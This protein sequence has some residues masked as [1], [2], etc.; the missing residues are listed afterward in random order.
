LVLVII[1]ARGF[2][3]PDLLQRLGERVDRRHGPSTIGA[4]QP[5][6]AIPTAPPVLQGFDPVPKARHPYSSLGD[7]HGKAWRL[8]GIR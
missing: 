4:H 6:A 7:N 3:R 8:A 1:I 5:L 2:P